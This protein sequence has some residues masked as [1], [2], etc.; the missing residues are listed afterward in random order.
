MDMPGREGR[1]AARRHGTILLR[2][3]GGYTS[4]L[5]RLLPIVSRLIRVDTPVC[6]LQWGPATS[7]WGEG[8]AASC[9]EAFV[10]VPA[11]EVALGMH[12]DGSCGFAWDN[13]GPRQ[14]GP[15]SVRGCLFLSVRS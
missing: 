1:C 7:S 4:T 10:H 9:D 6:L 11:G 5:P 12:L 2:A 14:V 13:E 15:I 8:K 3:A